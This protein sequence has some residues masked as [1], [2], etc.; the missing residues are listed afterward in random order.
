VV[1]FS[2]ADFPAPR[3]ARAWLFIGREHPDDFVILRYARHLTEAPPVAVAD[4]GSSSENPAKIRRRASRHASR[5]GLVRSVRQAARG[6]IWNTAIPDAD[7]VVVSPTPRCR[8]EVLR[9]FLSVARRTVGDSSSACRARGWGPFDAEYTAAS[10][11]RPYPMR[12]RAASSSDTIFSTLRS[13][14]PHF[15]RAG[16]VAARAARVTQLFDPFRGVMLMIVNSLDHGCRIPPA[17]RYRRHDRRRSPVAQLSSESMPRD[18]AVKEENLGGRQA[19][20]DKEGWYHC[21]L[22]R[23]Q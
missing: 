15:E 20:Q 4:G 18:D 11:F 14:S 17:D 13:S 16:R 1:T 23:P 3:P 10:V 5:S 7:H 19:G 6:A 8:S 9:R 22:K 2:L 12:H 21:R